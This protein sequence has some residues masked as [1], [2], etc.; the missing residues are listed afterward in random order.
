VLRFDSELLVYH[1]NRY[2][3]WQ[4]LRQRIDHGMAFGSDRAAT[5]SRRKLLLM[6]LLSP[7]IPWVFFGKILGAVR[8]DRSYYG[9][10]IK[11]MPLLFFFACGW[12]LGETKAYIL[13]LGKRAAR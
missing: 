11:C 1:H 2:K 7:A 3:T 13:S 9:Y 12:S 5:M 6:C 10:T 4:F 8:R